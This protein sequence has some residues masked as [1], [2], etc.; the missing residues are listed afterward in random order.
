MVG[1]RQN[2]PSERAA[3]HG[4][5]AVL[6]AGFCLSAAGLPARA[7]LF[8]DDEARRAIIELR[9]RVE[10][11]RLA[12]EAADKRL[13]DELRRLLDEQRRL[14]EAATPTRRSLI[15]LGNQI[16]ALR[17]E[18]A[19]LNGQNEQ[20]ARSVADLQ[21]QQ[22]D[23]WAALDERLRRLEPAKV[24]HDGRSFSA[25]ADEQRE[26]EA[27]LSALRASQFDASA[28]GFE[29]FLRRYPE[30]GYS[31]SALYW[32]G[33]AQYALRQYRPAI[34][35]YRRLLSTTPDHVR[36]PEAMLAI[37]NCQIE[38]KDSRAAR[39]TLDDLVK[40]HPQT[41]AAVAARDR[42]AKLR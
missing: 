18:I 10:N 37:A 30:S 25:M 38:L 5:L 19:R 31:P 4:L 36:V 35:S 6:I 32:L 29:R 2:A 8:G 34:E 27:A 15:D 24:T 14:D 42:I 39:K 11:Q 22:K 13:S 3:G 23:V 28:E 16:E 41:E 26:F 20:L 7:A 21:R 33:N 1:I 12:T 40:A 9:E 17:T